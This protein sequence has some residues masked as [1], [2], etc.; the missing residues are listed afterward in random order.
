M[1][2]IVRRIFFHTNRKLFNSLI[3]T[4]FARI[5]LIR[6]IIIDTLFLNGLV[7]II[8]II[9]NNILLFFRKNVLEFSKK[10]KNGK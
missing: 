5:P 7:L 3:T 1:R 9:N 8:S 6:Y 2:Y 10:C 4:D